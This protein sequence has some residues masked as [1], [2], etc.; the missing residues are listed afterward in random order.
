M[1]NKW[2]IAFLFAALFLTFFFQGPSSSVQTPPKGSEPSEEATWDTPEDVARYYR[3]QGKLPPN[4]ITK[5][6]AQALGWVAAEGNLWEV[7]PGK[8][9]GGDRF[10]NR[11]GL[12]PEKEGRLWYECDMDY[13]GGPRGA[14]R[15]VYSNDGLFYYTDNH[16][17]SFVELDLEENPS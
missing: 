7:A 13:H 12:L 4:F 10:F 5:K 15:L 11:E 1:R 14:K 9:I 8:S 3:D 16:Y 17:K 6:E 2:I